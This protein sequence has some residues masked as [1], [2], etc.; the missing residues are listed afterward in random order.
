MG[1]PTTAFFAGHPCGGVAFFGP[2]RQELFCPGAWG[3]SLG[4]GLTAI[5]VLG[6]IDSFQNFL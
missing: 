2:G 1:Y 4:L 5:S 3:G 6:F